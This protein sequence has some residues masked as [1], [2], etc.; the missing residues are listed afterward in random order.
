MYSPVRVPAASSSHHCAGR[1]VR[2]QVY[3][4]YNSSG[5]SKRFL[6]RQSAVWLISRSICELGSLFKSTLPCPPCQLLCLCILP[7]A[8]L[9]SIAVFDLALFDN[10]SGLPFVDFLYLDL[11]CFASLLPLPLF[12]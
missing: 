5:S 6:S 2:Q 4:V 8:R 11:D 12:G 9:D 7:G 3:M 10:S 1:R